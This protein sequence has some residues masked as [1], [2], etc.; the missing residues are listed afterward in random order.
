LITD[1]NHNDKHDIAVWVSIATHLTTI[2]RI[3][4]SEYLFRKFRLCDKTIN[5]ILVKSGSLG[6]HKSHEKRSLSIN[7]L[8]VFTW[9]KS[10]GRAQVGAPL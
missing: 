3:A 1:Q 6:V 4:A 7:V 5:A 9:S 8:L 2:V 10:I